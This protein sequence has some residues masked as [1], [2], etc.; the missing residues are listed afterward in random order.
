M[1]DLNDFLY[2]ELLNLPF[3]LFKIISEYIAI[4]KNE[5]VAFVGGYLRDLLIW[6]IHKGK[7][8]KPIDLDIVVEGSA[9]NL[10]IFIKKNI[11]NV[12][13]CLI[14]EFNLYKTVEVNINDLKIDIASARK[15][16]YPS[17]G[18]NPIIKDSNIL[19]DLKR[20]DFTINTLAFEISNKELIDIHNGL[21]HI[22]TKKLHLLHNESIKDDPSRILRC[23]KYSS[24]LG[25]KLDKNSLEQ[26]QKF[27]LKWPWDVSE[28]DN[29]RKIPPGISIRL[30]MELSEI[31]K[32][33]DL[34]KI[35]KILHEWQVL[36]IIN[37]DITLNAK[38]LRGLH[39]VQRLK[40]KIILY[41]TKDSKSLESI[42]ERLFLN[43]KD[44]KIIQDYFLIK[45]KLIN[46]EE[47]FLNFSPSN[48]TE[49]IE[50]KNLDP[51]TV[52]LI[53]CDGGKFWR[54]FLRWLITYRYI[55]SD[56]NG[57]KLKEEGWKPGKEMGDELKR[58]RFIQIDNL[59]KH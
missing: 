49:F 23:A 30:R 8:L 59:R 21:N 35:I 3:N 33:D 14:K 34:S 41:L 6:Q 43:T 18:F 39:W 27:I 25:F 46:K 22:Y 56:K 15:E 31:I 9:I 26:A 38:F 44:L 36:S 51:E 45:N 55:K 53:I 11:K 57:K 20:R 12:D 10:A 42:G 52:K 4:N 2:K 47:K 58:L 40:G 37:E 1:S 19:D 32:H 7:K 5:K 24:R 48:W 50:G 28:E 54:N 29:K 13:L 16:I 17:P